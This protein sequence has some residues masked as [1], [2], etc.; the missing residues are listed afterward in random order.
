MN[1]QKN[2]KCGQQICLEADGN[3]HRLTQSRLAGQ[4]DEEGKSQH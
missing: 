3:N 2:Y 1:S 4:E